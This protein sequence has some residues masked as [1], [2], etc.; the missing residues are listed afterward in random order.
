MDKPGAFPFL[1]GLFAARQDEQLRMSTAKTNAPPAKGQGAAASAAKSPALTPTPVHVPPLFRKIDW[2]TFAVT[3]VLV[4]IGYYLTLAPDL[5]LED[6]GEMAVAS[7]YAGI[8]HPPGYPVWTLYSWLFTAI[9]PVSN[10]AWR[11]AVSSAVAGALACGLLGLLVSRGSSMMM[12]GIADLKNIDRRWE[13]AICV[14]SG[15]VAGMLLGFDGFMWS[16]SVIVEVYALTVLSLMAVLLCLLRWTYAPHQHRYVYLA[17][18]LFGICFCNHQS[19]LVIALG[20]EVLILMV[21]PKLAREMFFWNSILFIVGLALGPSILTSNNAL[22]TIYWI[23]GV[24]SLGA[25]LW[26]AINTKKR[27]IELGRDF[28]MLGTFGYLAV[29]LGVVTG[30]ITTFEKSKGG[31]FVVNI[32]GIACTIGFVRLIQLTRSQSRDWLNALFC[33]GSWFLGA[34]FYLYMPLAGATNPPMQW[35]YPRTLEGFIHAF[36]RGQYERIR[37]TTGTGEGIEAISSF[38]STYTKQVW[39]FLEGLNDE[40]NVIY[41][42]IALVMFL[43]YRRM[44]ARERAWTIGVTAIFF[45][46][47]PFLIVLFNP[48]PD[49]QARELIRVFFTASHVL[50]ALGVGYGLS[51]IVASLA[52]HYDRFRRVATLGGAVAVDLALFSLAVVTYA[53]LGDTEPGESNPIRKFLVFVF[54]ALCATS[55][56]LAAY[57]M[58]VS[59]DAVNEERPALIG[60]SSIG[61]VSLLMGLVYSNNIE[62]GVEQSS[63]VGFAKILCWL[64]TA[65]CLYLAQNP[66]RGDDRTIMLAISGLLA[67][68]SVGM[69]AMT[70]LGDKPSLGTF[71]S[72]LAGAFQPGQYAMPVLASLILLGMAVAFVVASVMFKSRAPLGLALVIFAIMPLHPILSHWFENE[73]RGHLFG[74]WFGHDMFTPPFEGPDGKFSYDPKL[75]AEMMKDPEK[76]RLTY[77]EMTRDAILYGGTDPGRFCPTYMTFC[78]SFIPPRCKVDTDPNFDRRDVYV[79]TQNALA[80]GTYLNYIRAHYNR[81][82]QIDSPFFQD[83]LRGQKE[84]EQNYKTNFLARIA[85][86]L[87]DKPLTALGASI[88]ARRRREGVYPPREMYIATPDDS[89]R[90]FHE[91]LMDAQKRLAHDTQFPNAPRQIR[92]GEDVK[93]VENRVQ[94]SGQVAVMTINGLITKVMFDKNP[95]NEFFV[96]ESF[97]LEWMYPHLTPFG[98]IMKINRQT[99]PTLPEEVLA[100][101]HAFWAKYSERLIGNWITYD[102]PVRDIVKFAEKVYL[103]RDLSDF[104]GDRKFVRDDQAQKAFSKLRSSIGGIYAWRLGPQAS[105]EYRPK[106]TAEIERLYKEADFTFKQSFAFCPYSPEAV[107]RYI[108]LLVQPPPPIAPRLDDALIVAE[109]CLKLD[110]YNGQVLALVNNLR[111]AR[112]GQADFDKA[113]ASLQQMEDTVRNNPTNFQ[114]ALDLAA[115]YFQMQ[116]TDRAMAIFDR[117]ITNSQSNPNVILTIARA[118]AEMGN[119]AKLEITLEQLVKVLPESPEAWYDLAAFKASLNKTNEVV[120]PLMKALELNDQ[121]LAQNPQAPNL[122]ISNRNDARFNSLRTLPEYQNLVAPR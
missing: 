74:Y 118:Y 63:V 105:P 49:R 112:K 26:L 116:Q 91:Y 94:V 17:F 52:T 76:A 113:R 92:P 44:Q 77:P 117:L 93:I 16:Q 53:L 89:Q 10:I 69:T 48:P 114:A 23:I 12:E 56:V 31:L 36:T 57:R 121:R 100:R 5:T 85:V 24:S 62:T 11:V 8:P 34:A 29:I 39:M 46:L 87:L 37:P 65:G 96:E 111:S 7:Y 14:V 73:Q 32:L 38:I 43:Y 67:L 21:E 122:H 1:Y 47:G 41:V 66:K 104:K 88:E 108:N 78:E 58:F 84:R 18:F 81:S 3:T 54:F 83:L 13:S 82:T 107:F 71:V 2:F 4:L 55:F 30:W 51:L 9:L 15:F 101:D 95:T 79:I 106:T 35:G 68:L 40:F 97:P 110:P 102:T 86:N 98:V 103:R 50:V 99:L 28:C 120:A 45:C 22:L 19:L 80:D 42:F 33:G 6:S 72:T 27:L 59:P 115:T 119:W 25:W 75:R 60:L 20:M 90:C 109:T 64:L 61:L 70:V